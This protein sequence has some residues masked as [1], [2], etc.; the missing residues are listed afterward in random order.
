LHD[1]IVALYDSNKEKIEKLIDK[2][3]LIFW[4]ARIM[5]NQYHSKTSPFFKKYRKYYRIMDER[6]VLGTWQDQYI[7]NTPDRIHRIIDE[8]GVKLKKQLEKDIERINKRLKEIHWFDSEIFR[9]YH[10][11]GKQFSLNKMAEETGISRSTIYKS[12]KKVEKL[13]ENER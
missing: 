9:I 1:T 10:M 11:M 3:E 7:N 13:F 2:K 5:I 12:I 8:D 6:F 4:I